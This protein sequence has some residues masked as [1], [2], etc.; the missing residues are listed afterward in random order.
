[1]GGKEHLVGSLVTTSETVKSFYS[2]DMLFF[3]HQ[4]AEDDIK[5]KPEWKSA[6]PKYKA[7]GNNLEGCS[8]YESKEHEMKY[9][10]P[11]AFLLM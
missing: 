9:S 8:Y 7:F 11:F 1:M 3:R 2:D 4:R 10:C 5:L 6:Y